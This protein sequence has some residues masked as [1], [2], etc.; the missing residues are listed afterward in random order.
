MGAKPAN[1]V[2]G[3]A[4][5]GHLEFLALHV[6]RSRPSVADALNDV[7]SRNRRLCP[8]ATLSQTAKEASTRQWIDALDRMA[9]EASVDV[10]P[11]R[12]LV[13]V[14]DQ[15]MFLEVLLDWCTTIYRTGIARVYLTARLLRE[16]HEQGKQIAQPIL[17]LLDRMRC[18]V[19]CKENVYLLVELL[20]HSGHFDA[21]KYLQWLISCGALNRVTS[22][23]K[24]R[25][26]VGLAPLK[27]SV[28]V[29][30]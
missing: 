2:L 13:R 22:L 3:K 24:V 17:S 5:S 21:G 18:R 6:D 12:S 20:V 14:E 29:R 28:A 1:F 23:S 27:R 19:C 16:W 4:W 7:L 15:A 30:R 25:A 10:L 11:E 9:D 26:V 8:S